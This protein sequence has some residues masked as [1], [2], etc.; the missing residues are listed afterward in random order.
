M[1]YILMRSGGKYVGAWVGGWLGRA[2]KVVRDNLGFGLM[3]QAGVA[4]GLA[5][6]SAERFTDLGPA[7]RELAGLIVNVI[8]ATTFVVQVIGP[9]F[10]K[11]AIRQ[12]GEIGGAKLS[13]DVWASEGAPE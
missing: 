10:V 11:H 13:E 5:I 8:T 2:P 12:A 6:A 1:A 7:G 3:S 4:I 9:L